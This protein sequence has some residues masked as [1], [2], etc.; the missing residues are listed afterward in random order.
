MQGS[1]LLVCCFHHHLLR[2]FRAEVSKKVKESDPNRFPWQSIPLYPA[3][4]LAADSIILNSNSKQG[5]VQ[6]P[7][8]APGSAEAA[9]L[10]EIANLQLSDSGDNIGMMQLNL[11]GPARTNRKLAGALFALGKTLRCGIWASAEF[12]FCLASATASEEIR[13]RAG[14]VSRRNKFLHRRIPAAE[15]SPCPSAPDYGSRYPP[16]RTPAQE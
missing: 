6:L 12:S 2:I 9:P 3:P 14:L 8:A 1:T 4:R 5:I 7:R 11:I 13:R 10:F 16:L 15:C